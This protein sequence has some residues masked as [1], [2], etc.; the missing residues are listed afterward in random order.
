MEGLLSHKSLL[1]IILLLALLAA[2][3]WA[4]GH[5]E[6]LTISA[7]EGRLNALGLWAPLVFILIYAV[8]TVLFLPGSVLTI[9]GGA[10]FGPWFGTL[11]NL[12]GATLGAALA[13]LVAR[14]L[15]A[16]WVAARVGRGRL[17]RLI[18]GVEQEGWRFVAFTRLVPIFPFN[19]LNYALGLTRIPWLQY[20][21][22]TVVCIAPGTLAYTWIGYASVTAV[23]GGHN[24]AEAVLIALGLLAGLLFLPR[25]VRR[26]RRSMMTS[27]VQEDDSK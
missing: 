19:V 13:F 21:F 1:R 12:L 11:Y 27:A 18:E 9:A 26:L 20:V 16:E 14:Y 15:A 5:R 24:V 25:L 2:I 3:G 17:G 6:A 23:R 10:I 8:A 4:I 7:L 22:A